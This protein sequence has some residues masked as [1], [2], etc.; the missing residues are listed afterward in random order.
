MFKEVFLKSQI[1]LA[2]IQ[3]NI[4]NFKENVKIIENSLKFHLYLLKMF[5]LS[6]KYFVFYKY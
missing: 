1:C 2:N 4:K 6:F 3:N 5:K